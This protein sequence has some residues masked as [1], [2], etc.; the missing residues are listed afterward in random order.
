[1]FTT[2]ILAIHILVCVALIMVILLQ[3]GKGADIGAVFGGGSSNTV[4]GSTG[5]TPFLS[6]VTI[7]AAVLFMVTSIILTYFSGKGVA[8]EVLGGWRIWYRSSGYCT[9]S[10]RGRS[11]WSGRVGYTWCDDRSTRHGSGGKCAFGSSA[12]IGTSA[13]SGSFAV[14][15]GKSIGWQH[16]RSWRLRQVLD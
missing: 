12:E 3:S 4:F 13:R 10:R 8:K 15:P 16:G 6:K 5:A 14:S 2:I 11:S 1:M 7:A 9:G